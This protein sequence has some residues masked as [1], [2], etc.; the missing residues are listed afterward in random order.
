[1]ISV[2]S[3][4]LDRPIVLTFIESI[5]KRLLIEK[6]AYIKEVKLS[7]PHVKINP[8]ENASLPVKSSLEPFERLM[9]LPMF[10]PQG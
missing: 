3:Q 7:S 9:N 6:K 10:L 2:E 4:S 1:M 8:V 5:E